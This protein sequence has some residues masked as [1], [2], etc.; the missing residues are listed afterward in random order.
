MGS[1]DS[2]PGLSD[3]P[4]AL[5]PSLGQAVTRAG[6]TSQHHLGQEPFGLQQGSAA[7]GSVG[8]GAVEMEGRDSHRLLPQHHH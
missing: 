5:E 2:T 8:S 4:I 3:L 7:L 6:I 1:K